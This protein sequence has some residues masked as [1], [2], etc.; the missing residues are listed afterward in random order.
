MT[1]ND[2]TEIFQR[3]YPGD[4]SQSTKSNANASYLS[5]A[6]R[7][8]SSHLSL[9]YQSSHINPLNRNTNHSRF[10]SSL[11]LLQPRRTPPLS[12]P[13]RTIKPDS[14]SPAPAPGPSTSSARS[15]FLDLTCSRLKLSISFGTALESFTLRV[16][17][18]RCSPHFW[19]RSFR[20]APRFVLEWTYC[21]GE[22]GDTG[23]VG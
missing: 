9:S 7:R 12:R 14:V 5:P 17:A 1:C 19:V 11:L 10:T 3:P 21:R 2:V 23:E 8:A 15:G 4:C 20:A 22:V 13:S 16:V 6:N 18:A